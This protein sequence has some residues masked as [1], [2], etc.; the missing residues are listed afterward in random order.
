VFEEGEDGRGGLHKG[1]GRGRLQIRRGLG[2]GVAR[3]RG[4]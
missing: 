3:V 2:G 1:E 4:N